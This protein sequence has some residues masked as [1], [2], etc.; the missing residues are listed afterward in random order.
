MSLAAVADKLL[1]VLVAD[2]GMSAWA[3]AYFA[4]PISTIKGN[5]PVALVAPDTLPVIVCE[6]GDGTSEAE[7]LGGD[8]DITEAQFELA[9]LW[10]E[11]DTE[12]AFAQRAELATHFI[13]AVMRDA[14]L[15]GACAAAHIERWSSDR[16]ANHPNQLLRATVRVEL[17]TRI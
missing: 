12:A 17:E 13:K 10:Q 14:T 15:G 4:R 1:A 3:D 7:T 9:M 6:L 8:I 11:Q 2:A 5:K 16:G